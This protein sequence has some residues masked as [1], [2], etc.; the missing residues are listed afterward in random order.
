MLQLRARASFKY[1]TF[2]GG[3]TLRS[4]SSASIGPIGIQYSSTGRYVLDL[5]STMSTGRDP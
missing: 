3:H 2:R 1:R 4:A 5:A